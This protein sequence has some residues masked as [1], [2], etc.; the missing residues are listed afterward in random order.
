MMV[1][2]SP[3]AWSNSLGFTLSSAHLRSSPPNVIIKLDIQS[4]N[5]NCLRSPEIT[6]EFLV[7]FLNPCQVVSNI[8]KLPQG[9]SRQSKLPQVAPSNLGTVLMLMYVWAMHLYTIW[10]LHLSTIWN[11]TYY[12]WTHPHTTASQEGLPT[13]HHHLPFFTSLT[14]S[15]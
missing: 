13:Y 12:I 11:N 14:L 8:I 9:M 5:R 7:T 4:L 3:L 2:K 6:W 15:E 1:E 10:W